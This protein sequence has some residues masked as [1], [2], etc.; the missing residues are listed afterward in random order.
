[1]RLANVASAAL[2]DSCRAKKSG[3]VALIMGSPTAH[4]TGLAMSYSVRL[5]LDSSPV[6]SGDMPTA[7]KK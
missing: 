6:N 7:M 3:C 1:M 5:Y 2:N 4:S